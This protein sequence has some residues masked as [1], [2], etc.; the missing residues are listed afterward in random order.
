MY[1]YLVHGP[2]LLASIMNFTT[3]KM[4]YRSI[5]RETAAGKWQKAS[6]SC[7][8]AMPICLDMRTNLDV[9]IRTSSLR[10]KVAFSTNASNARR[11]KKVFS[12]RC[13]MRKLDNKEYRRS[14]CE[15]NHR[16]GHTCRLEI[17]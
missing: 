9:E 3:S 4:Q 8:M 2:V 17:S 15:G 14:R 7:V 13:M 11:Q 1:S 5:W 16:T 10:R 12:N 6:G